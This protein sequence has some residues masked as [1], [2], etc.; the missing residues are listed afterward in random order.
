MIVQDLQAE[1]IRRRFHQDHIAGLGEQ[2]AHL[3]DRI[4]VAG[5][6][7]ALVETHLQAF[8]Q[9]RAFVNPAKHGHAPSGAP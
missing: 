8:E 1:V 3:I 2:R 6:A 7:D 9:T 4:R 5:G